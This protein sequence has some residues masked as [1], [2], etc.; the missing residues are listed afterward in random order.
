MSARCKIQFIVVYVIILAL[1]IPKMLAAKES[2]NGESIL[3]TEQL[4]IK[5]LNAKGIGNRFAIGGLRSPIDDKKEGNIT[6]RSTGNLLTM[7][8]VFKGDTDYTFYLGSD[9][10]MNLHPMMLPLSIGSIYRFS[11]TVKLFLMEDYAGRF[12]SPTGEVDTNIPEL[13]QKLVGTYTFASEGD[14]SSLLTFVMVKEKGLVF[15]RGKGRLML[16]NGEEIKL[17]Y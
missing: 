12:F 14:R 7:T 2:Q 4:L 3:E 17:G 10:K 11:G 16:P 6:F 8:A 1:A 13:K 15:L 5:E 9:G